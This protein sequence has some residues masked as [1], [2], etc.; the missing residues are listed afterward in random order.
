[1]LSINAPNFITIAGMAIVG[2]LV[3]SVVSQ[4]VKRGWPSKESA[5]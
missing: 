4:L 1:L 5:A 2:W 3:L